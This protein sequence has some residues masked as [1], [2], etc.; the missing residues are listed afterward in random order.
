MAVGAA[1]AGRHTAQVC[2]PPVSG[3]RSI[4]AVKTRPAPFAPSPPK[5][6][7]YGL[8]TAGVPAGSEIGTVGFPTSASG[9]FTV[10]VPFGPGLNVP[11][12]LL[13]VPLT[14]PDEPSH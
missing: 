1:F 9:T 3:A 13:L 8:R 10:I 4:G 5:T 11:V 2:P 12:V 7:P 14:N 6:M